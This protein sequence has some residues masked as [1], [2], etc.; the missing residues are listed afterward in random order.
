MKDPKTL[1]DACA[2]CGH[3]KSWHDEVVGCVVVIEE[4]CSSRPIT[5]QCGCMEFKEEED[6]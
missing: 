6:K 4:S 5:E 2:N 1:R 3:H